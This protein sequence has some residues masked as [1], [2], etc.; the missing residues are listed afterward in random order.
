MYLTS[1]TEG[2]LIAL[3]SCIIA[4]RLIAYLSFR[5]IDSSKGVNM[6]KT[7][8]FL[9]IIGCIT[10]SLWAYLVGVLSA[11]GI[12]LT[13]FEGDVLV[14]YIKTRH[15]V[16]GVGGSNPLMPTRIP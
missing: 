5:S 4:S 15:G 9:L 10:E 16:S 11:S 7:Q 6:N 1:T 3:V 12:N 2:T 14:K 8:F 13:S